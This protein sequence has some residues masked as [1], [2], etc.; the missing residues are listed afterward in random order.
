[1]DGDTEEFKRK[2]RKYLNIFVIIRVFSWV[3]ITS[4]FSDFSLI[5]LKEIIYS[6]PLTKCSLC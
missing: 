4:E 2:L 1:M 5:A 6:Y 3:G